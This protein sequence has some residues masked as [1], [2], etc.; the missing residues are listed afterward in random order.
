V[1]QVGDGAG[2]AVPLDTLCSGL[3]MLLGWG[4]VLLASPPPC[5][6]G[7]PGKQGDPG[8]DVSTSVAGAIAFARG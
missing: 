1:C 4:W 8:R 5:L 3:G 6:Q 2:R 7:D